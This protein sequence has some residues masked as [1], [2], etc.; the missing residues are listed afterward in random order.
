MFSSNQIGN[1]VDTFFP[2]R[3]FIIHPYVYFLNCKNTI[4][5]LIIY[6]SPLILWALFGLNYSFCKYYLLIFDVLF[7][8]DLSL[9]GLI[10]STSH[11]DIWYC[12]CFSQVIETGTDS[13]LTLSNQF[14]V[15]YSHWLDLHLHF[16]FQSENSIS[17]SYIWLCTID[18]FGH[19]TYLY[20][21]LIKLIL[22]CTSSIFFWLN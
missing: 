17:G 3:F 12:S 4:F 6:I 21:L 2:S 9:Q 1:Q 13:Y 14:S 18:A 10:N 19:K 22:L 20:N 11:V 16:A 7:I 5:S 15:G 8:F